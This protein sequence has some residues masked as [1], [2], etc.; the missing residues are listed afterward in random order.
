MSA[1]DYDYQLLKL[2]PVTL[3]GGVAIVRALA[4]PFP[5]ARFL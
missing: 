2:F 3:L 4:G 1:L 5:E